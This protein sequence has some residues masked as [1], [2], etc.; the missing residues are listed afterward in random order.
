MVW[1]C[2]N[3]FFGKLSLL[4]H[5]DECFPHFQR[6][7]LSTMAELV[8]VVGWTPKDGEHHVR[9]L[10]R[11]LA[12]SRAG[13]FGHEA[14]VAEAKRRFKAHASGEAA[15]EADLRAPVYRVVAA[16]GGD[17]AFS[18]LVSLY[19]A[20]DL[21]EEKDRIGRAMGSAKDPAVLEKVLAFAV[22]ESVRAQDSPF[23]LISVS[24]NPAG[25][26]L[27]WKFFQDN[28]AML[29]KDSIVTAFWQP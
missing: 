27:A 3:S 22:S 7:V 1:S 9:G 13:Q 11:M 21:H 8:E 15:I 14:V 5:D 4:L 17:E 28:Y 29:G 2:I 24:A 19:E 18:Q 23:I 10:L 12:I 25:R 6:F 20:S 26:E 16:H